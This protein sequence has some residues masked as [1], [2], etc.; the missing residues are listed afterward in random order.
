MATALLAVVVGV[1]VLACFKAYHSVKLLEKDPEAWERL[2]KVEEEKRRRRQEV[3][4]KVLLNGTRTAWGWL[5]GKAEDLSAKKEQRP[6]V[7]DG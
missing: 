5:K 3:L 6:E 4:G 2:Q 7:S 1:V